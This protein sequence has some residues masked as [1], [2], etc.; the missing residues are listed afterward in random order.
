[1]LMPSTPFAPPQVVSRLFALFRVV[2]F[3]VSAA[4]NEFCVWFD[5]RQLHRSNSRSGCISA[6]ACFLFGHILGTSRN[7]AVH[8]VGHVVK[9]SGDWR[10]FSMMARPDWPTG[11]RPQIRNNCGAGSIVNGRLS[12]FGRR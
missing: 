9:V 2:K 7:K 6:L 10:S 3:G 12:Q 4:H 5:S 11:P 8:F 1:M